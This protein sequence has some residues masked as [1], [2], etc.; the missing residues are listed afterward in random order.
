MADDDLF[1]IKCSFRF[2]NVVAVAIVV[3]RQLKI[4]MK[5]VFY[6]LILNLPFCV[7]PMSGGRGVAVAA[8][9]AFPVY[10]VVVDDALMLLI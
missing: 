5:F 6:F 8:A 10:A 7:L 2:L 4:I 9:F 1:W 3:Y